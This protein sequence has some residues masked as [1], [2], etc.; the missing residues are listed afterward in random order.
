[1]TQPGTK[2]RKPPLRKAF[3][4]ELPLVEILDVGAMSE[5]EDRYAGLLAQE[6]ARVVGFEPNP[7]ELSRLQAMRVP[8]KRYLPYFLGK[9]GPATFHVTQYPGCCSLFE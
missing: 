8:G 7:A 9:G 3:G 2:V 6:L 5:G 1:M 4:I